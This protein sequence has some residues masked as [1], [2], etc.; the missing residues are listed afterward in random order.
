MLE[1]PGWSSSRLLVAVRPDHDNLKSSTQAGFR[2]KIRMGLSGWSVE[3]L[4]KKAWQIPPRW[5]RPLA[6]RLA[7]APGAGIPSGACPTTGHR[8]RAPIE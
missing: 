1:S 5:P 2:F 3:S 6:G 8:F 4:V 7:P